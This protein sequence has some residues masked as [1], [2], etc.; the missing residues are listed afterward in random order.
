MRQKRNPQL[1]LFMTVANTQIGKE[2]EQMSL[3]SRRRYE[4]A[5][6]I[7]RASFCYKF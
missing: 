4:E 5:P 7:A 3:Y 2:L 6:V 1:N